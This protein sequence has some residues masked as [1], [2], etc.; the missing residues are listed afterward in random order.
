MVLYASLSPP[1]FLS[2]APSFPLSPSPNLHLFSL[3]QSLSLSPS[4]PPCFSFTAL[5]LPSLRSPFFDQLS[6]L[7]NGYSY[8]SVKR[9]T[10]HKKL[11]YHLSE[12]DKVRAVTTYQGAEG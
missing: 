11:G 4:F 10:L 9:W 3:P 1:F 7:G 12:C 8:S 2:L 5:I 6:S